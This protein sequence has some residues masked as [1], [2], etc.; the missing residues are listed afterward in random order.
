[1][2]RPGRYRFRAL[3]TSAG[4]FFCEL[5]DEIRDQSGP[6]GLVRCATAT[7]IVAVEV[8]MEQDVVLEMR[9]SLKFLVGAE[10]GTPAV[11]S[12]H[13]QLEHTAAQFIRDLVQ[14]QH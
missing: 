11:G 7:A 9:I 12:A 8:F 3:H 10:H 5:A 4:L 2:N 6:A 14:G 1:M 13:K